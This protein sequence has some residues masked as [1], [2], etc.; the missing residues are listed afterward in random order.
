M[1]AQGEDKRK[2]EEELED[3]KLRGDPQPNWRKRKAETDLED[4]VAWTQQK[5]PWLDPETGEALVLHKVLLELVNE[6]TE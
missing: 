2:A 3:E 1:Q 4:E 5:E 6:D